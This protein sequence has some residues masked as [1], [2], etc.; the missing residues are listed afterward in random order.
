MCKN[1]AHKL[2]L[3]NVQQ[4]NIKKHYKTIVY[5][6]ERMEISLRSDKMEYLPQ[7]LNVYVFE[8]TIRTLAC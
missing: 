4:T 6:L 1:I 5:S 3:V 2:N 7:A 8:N